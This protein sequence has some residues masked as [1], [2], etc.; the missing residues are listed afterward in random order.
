MRSH[1]GR[2]NGLKLAGIARIFEFSFQSRSCARF[3]SFLPFPPPDLLLRRLQVEAVQ[4]SSLP[5][6]IVE[7]HEQTTDDLAA[8]RLRRWAPTIARRCIRRWW[9]QQQK[10]EQETTTP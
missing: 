5:A 4:K 1:C 10:E 2:E 7:Y 9:Q 3:R 8:A 6:S